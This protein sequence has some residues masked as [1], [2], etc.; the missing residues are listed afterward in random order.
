[1]LA[2]SVPQGSVLEPTLFCL[3]F[4]TIL[5]IVCLHDC[6]TVLF[7]LTTQPEAHYSHLDLTTAQLKVNND[8]KNV[9]HWL[10]TEWD[11]CKC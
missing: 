7:A 11:D 5:L 4:N 9:Q 6:K 3:H 2:S 8:L 10:K 1:M